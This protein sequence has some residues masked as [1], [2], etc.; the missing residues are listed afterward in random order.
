MAT[1]IYTEGVRIP[2][3]RLYHAGELNRDVLDLLLL[4][5]RLPGERLADLRAQVAAARNGLARLEELFREHG[6]DTVLAA[7]EALYDQ[8]ERQ[9]RAAVRAISPGRYEFEDWLD[10]DGAGTERI[11]IRVAVIV[12]GDCLTF[13][14]SGSAPQVPGGVNLVLEGTRAVVQYVVKAV[15]EPTMPA[16]SGFT[17]AITIVAPPGSIT[18]SRSP[19]PT[20]NRSDT[21]QRLVD[22]CF[23]ALAQALPQRVIAASNGA[24]SGCQFFGPHAGGY[25]SYLE[26][27]G[28]GMGARPDRDGVDGV[29][30]HMTNTSNLPVEAL[31]VEYPLR[32][33]RHELVQ[34]SGGPGRFRGGMGLR[35]VY[36]VLEQGSRLRTKGDRHCLPPWGLAGGLP[37]ATG[38]YWIEA[39]DGSRRRVASK[40]YDQPLEPGDRVTIQTAGAGGHG[41]VAQRARES[42]LRDLLEERISP[43]AAEMAYGVRPEPGELEKLARARW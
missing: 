43:E 2:A 16:N 38:E 40:A 3:V 23:G 11:P 32:V 26:T 5:T 15:I 35:R 36:A 31:E 30:V 42:V 10:D 18:C 7:V 9:L 28:G 39:A 22:V 29:Q 6:T 4:N 25:Y 19:A 21:A 12:D 33:E 20:L 1:D 27:I 17:R 24:I 34:D 13:D 14:F 41:P 37:G 8:T